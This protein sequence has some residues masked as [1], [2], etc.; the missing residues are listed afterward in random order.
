M[1]I[2][3]ILKFGLTLLV[4][5]GVF[6]ITDVPVVPH[7]HD[8]ISIFMLLEAC[9]TKEQ[10]DDDLA[11]LQQDM[12][13][14]T[15][16]IQ[17]NKENEA[18]LKDQIAIYQ[19]RILLTTQ[20]IEATEAVIAVLEENIAT[21]KIEIEK[22]DAIIKE[23]LLVQQKQQNSN[24][25]LNLLFSS[26]SISDFMNRWSVVETLSSKEKE[27]LDELAQIKAE[28]EADRQEQQAQMESLEATKVNLS[29]AKAEREDLMNKVREEIASQEASLESM[30]S[31]QAEI[32]EQRAILMRPAP[33]SGGL[34]AGEYGYW[35]LPVSPGAYITTHF[36]QMYE[37]ADA[38]HMGTDIASGTNT[39]I[40]S[41]ADGYVLAAGY[42]GMF[43]NMVAVGHIID[44][45]S[46]VSM[47]AHMNYLNVSAGQ[48]VYG[49]S[50]VLGG[51]GNTGYSFGTHLHLELA[52][53]DY[54][55]TSRG[56]RE[57][58]N[59]DALSKIG[60]GEAYYDIA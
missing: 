5:S 24:S 56:V 50:D 32:E 40:F 2:K 46:Y 21:K 57:S 10:C 47:Y 48:Y 11:R 59:I 51:M 15:A 38:P 22:K 44:G 55:T 29:E 16:K 12:D 23:Q 25:F 14:T 39:P 1:Y 27:I 37:Y 54:F 43:G 35:H 30:A 3:K 8:H 42:Y 45:V 4:A 52:V 19:E 33:G 13:N 49:G 9:E 36:R 17:Q 18:A 34:T 53:N 20:Q 31:S 6:Y 26:S 28:L 60:W 7:G 41:M 58:V